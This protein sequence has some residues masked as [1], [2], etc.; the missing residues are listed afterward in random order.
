M[1]YSDRI[2]SDPNIMLGKPVIKG[3]RITVEIILKRLGEGATK[4]DLLQ[5][6]PSISKED[7]NAV[8]EYAAGIIGNEEVINP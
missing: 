2:T 4:E 1:P 6:Y 7:I 5:M 8:L 3:T